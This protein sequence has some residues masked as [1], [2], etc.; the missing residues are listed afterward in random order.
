M[1]QAKVA[2]KIKTPTLYSITSH[3]PPENR[4]V[5]R[6]NVEKYC[7]AGQARHAQ[8]MLD[9]YGYKYTLRISNTFP[10]QQWLNS[11]RLKETSYVHC[12]FCL[13]IQLETQVLG[14]NGFHS[15]DS[16]IIL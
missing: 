4:T 6:D 5:L 15:L 12:L 1:F 7:T 8:C 16:R 13:M 10:L 2:E 14:F 3:P 11:T 9:R